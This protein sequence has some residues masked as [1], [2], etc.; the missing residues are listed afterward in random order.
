MYKRISNAEDDARLR[1]LQVE[2]IDRFGLL[3]EPTRTLFR[4][5]SL[6]LRAEG[7]GIKKI[8]AGPR[9]GKLEFNQDTPV[10]PGSIVELVQSEPHRYRLAAANQLAFEENMEK[11]EARFSKIERLF[12]RLEDRREAMAS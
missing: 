2:M 1:E 10:D 4:I 6:K 5:T 3:P 12:Q 11:P 7:L 9:G 8:D